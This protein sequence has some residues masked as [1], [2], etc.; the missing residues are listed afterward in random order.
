MGTLLGGEEAVGLC[1]MLIWK[2]TP[3]GKPLASYGAG[4]S[5][6]QNRRKNSRYV[7]RRSNNYK[8]DLSFY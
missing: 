5:Q 2:R 3:G 7:G 4:K 1:L 6:S 8:R